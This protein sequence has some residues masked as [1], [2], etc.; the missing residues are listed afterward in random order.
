MNIGMGSYIHSYIHKYINTYSTTI[1]HNAA[2]AGKSK[3]LSPILMNYLVHPLGALEP[4]Q[5]L[6]VDRHQW[7]SLGYDAY[8]HTYIKYIT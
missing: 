8:I 2:S 7:G 6:A 5:V 3:S 4:A 1:L